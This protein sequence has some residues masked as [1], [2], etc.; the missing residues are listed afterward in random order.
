MFR[1][2]RV[3]AGA[4]RTSRKDR[5]A[6]EAAKA[7]E[8]D[9]GTRLS[10]VP[11]QLVEGV[12]ELRRRANTCLNGSRRAELGQFLTPPEV[13]SFMSSMFLVRRQEIRLLDPGA[14]VGSL[15]AAFVSRMLDR[16]RAPRSITVVAYE[17]DPT[18][19]DLLEQSLGLCQQACARM[20]IR[21]EGEVRRVDYLADR[22]SAEAALFAQDEEPFDCVI[23]NPPYRKIHSQSASRRYLRNAGI[24]SSNI[25]PGFL[26]LAARQLRVGGE[27]VSINPRSFC[28]GP[29]FRPFRR[30]LLHLVALRRVHVFESRSEVFK[31]ADVLQENVIV[32]AVR[33]SDRPKSARISC[34]T[35]TGRVVSR[36]TP[37]SQIVSPDDPDAVVHITVDA[38]GEEALDAM[39][40]F[41]CTLDD[42]GLQ[43]STGRVVDFRARAYLR[44]EPESDTVPLIYPAHF[45]RGFVEWPNGNTRKPNAIVADPRVEDQLV[46]AGF[47][48]L[49]KRFS[50]KEE[51]RRVVAAVYDPHRVPARLI[52]LEN[53]LNYFHRRGGG[54]P[55]P[56]AR[57]LA[58]FL[59]STLVDQY[60]RQ[61][62]GHTQVNA[63]DLRRLRYPSTEQLSRL[64]RWCEDLGGQASIDS[65][66][67]HLLQAV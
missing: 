14:G 10:V 56:L 54:L 9:R 11:R 47:Y 21:F 61:F 36:L 46:P 40:N 51:R 3:T 15:T 39:R 1:G 65:A 2:D 60:F 38:Q 12:D 26:L 29:Y 64:A 58:V 23:M 50:A 53:H 25:Y 4:E 44:K 48:V 42:L 55:E 35:A 31:D 37:Y 59:N 16:Q 45:S 34:T 52:G 19:A 66:M 7:R 30:E 20:H 13:A 5:M 8:H 32:H 17:V 24:E 62:S 57:G 28:N 22:S 43:V 33:R 18:L 67:N 27:L 6:V 49:T 41:R 63:A